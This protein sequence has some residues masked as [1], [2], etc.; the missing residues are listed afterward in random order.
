MGYFKEKIKGSK[1][2]RIMGFGC[3][4]L[5]HYYMYTILVYSLLMHLILYNVSVC[6]N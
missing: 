3:F 2:K 4:P 5:F 1:T 6:V